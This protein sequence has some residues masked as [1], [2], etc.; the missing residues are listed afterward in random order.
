MK[1]VK[2]EISIFS[3]IHL[4]MSPEFLTSQ[5]KNKFTAGFKLRLLLFFY[6]S[7]GHYNVATLQDHSIEIIV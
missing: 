5:F 6:L 7:P 2:R 3:E 4:L 1:T